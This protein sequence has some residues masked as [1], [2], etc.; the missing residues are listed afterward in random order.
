[1]T[2]NEAASQ[3]DDLLC[4]ASLADTGELPRTPPL[5]E[6]PDVIPSGSTAVVDPG[7]YFTANYAKKVAKPVV[8]EEK[9]LIY[10]RGKNLAP[11]AQNGDVYVYWARETELDDPAAWQGNQLLTDTGQGSFP[12]T[13]V[14]PGSITVATTPFV[15]TP[16]ALANTKVVLIGVLAT[17]DHPNP[18]PTLKPPFTFDAWIAKQGGVGAFQTTVAPKPP[19]DTTLTLSGDLKFVEGGPVEIL[20]STPVEGRIITIPLTKI[21]QNPQTIGVSAT[22][23]ANYTSAV[24]TK[25]ALARGSTPGPNNSVVT[26]VQYLIPAASGPVKPVILERCSIRFNR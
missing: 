5:K 10:V 17:N 14:E 6:S 23:P 24:E 4:R 7:T 3:Y 12:V 26:R 2:R 16:D 13:G 20:I 19:S 11:L 15:W 22:L 9:N 21:T 1:M 8:S 18:V 25:I